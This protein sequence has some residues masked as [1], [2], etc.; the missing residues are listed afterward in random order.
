VQFEVEVVMA[1]IW[2]KLWKIVTEVGT[3]GVG[4]RKTILAMNIIYGCFREMDTFREKEK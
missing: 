4:C 2:T 1:A 3:I